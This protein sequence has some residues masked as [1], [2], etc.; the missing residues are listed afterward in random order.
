MKKQRGGLENSLKRR[1]KRDGN[2]LGKVPTSNFC[3]ELMLIKNKKQNK[4]KQNKTK[5]NKSQHV[6]QTET[7]YLGLL[8]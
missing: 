4:T 7:L 5:Q 1:E 6:S 2:A 3:M 8:W